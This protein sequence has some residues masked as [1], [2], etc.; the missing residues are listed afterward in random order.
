MQPV[1]E[2]G[3]YSPDFFD[4]EVLF[5]L[6]TKAIRR[7]IFYSAAAGTAVLTLMLFGIRESRPSMLLKR[8]I[9]KIAKESPN[10]E[11]PFR[12]AD[13]SGHSPLSLMWFLFVPHG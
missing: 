4:Q 13:P 12:T 1:L 5:V 6:T 10:A 9:A 2:T 7:W 3:A 8:K 11:L